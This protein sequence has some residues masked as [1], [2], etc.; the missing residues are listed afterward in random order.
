MPPQ[1]KLQKDNN[2]PSP[3]PY[4]VTNVQ[5]LLYLELIIKTTF[6]LQCR[7]AIQKPAKKNTKRK[8]Y[9]FLNHSCQLNTKLNSSTKNYQKF[10]PSTTKSIFQILS[11]K[12]NS[13]RNFSS[14]SRRT[15]IKCK[16]P[17]QS[18]PSKH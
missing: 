10:M 17:K 18:P 11:I 3:W 16:A 9:P 5:V 13:L 15:I 14:H 6:L 12:K 2:P 1:T 4:S 8:P 7:T